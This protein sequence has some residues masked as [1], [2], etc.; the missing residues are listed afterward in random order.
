MET[1]TKELEIQDEAPLTRYKNPP[2]F[3]VVLHNDDYTT[4]DFVVEI[5]KRFFQKQEEE[6]VQIMLNI[7]QMGKAVAGIYDLEIA[8]TKVMQV[9]ESA[10]SRG[11]PLRCS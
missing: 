3:G 5:L 10:R 2:R 6:A 7:H 8:E 11:Y 9:H 4:M 1:G